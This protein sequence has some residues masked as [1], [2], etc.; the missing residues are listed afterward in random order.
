MLFQA[1]LGAAAF[2]GLAALFQQ[3]L[4]IFARNELGM[5]IK[6]AGFP[7]FFVAAGIVAGSWLA[8][9]YGRNTLDAGCVPAGA[10]AM[11]LGLVAIPLASSRIVFDAA[12]VVAGIG[13]GLCLVPLN[14]YLQTG[15]D[16][17]RRGEILGASETASFFAIVLSSGLV[18]LLGDLIGL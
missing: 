7:F 5:T 8:G 2:S 1:A 11:T 6:E 9:R 13:G 4:V 15:S 12:L 17:D 18:A 14:T 3:V 10:L 16:A